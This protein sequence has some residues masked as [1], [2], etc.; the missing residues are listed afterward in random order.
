MD[1][2]TGGDFYN[3]LKTM[4]AKFMAFF[5]CCVSIINNPKFI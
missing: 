1:L 5:Y 3:L 4:K 2:G